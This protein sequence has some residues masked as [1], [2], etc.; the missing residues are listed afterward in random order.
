MRSNLNSR[1]AENVRRLRQELRLSQEDAAARCGLH[2]TYLGA[3]E[4][5]ERNIT[6]TTLEQI[7]EGLGTDPLSLLRR[8]RSRQ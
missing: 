1:L 4:R 5:A 3:V 2:R 7:A 8:G 6:L